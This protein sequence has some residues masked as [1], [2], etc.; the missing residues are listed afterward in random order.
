MIFYDEEGGEKSPDHPR[1]GARL[2]SILTFG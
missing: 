1:A 2:W